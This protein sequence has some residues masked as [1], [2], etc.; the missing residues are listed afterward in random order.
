MFFSKRSNFITRLANDKKQALIVRLTHLAEVGY[1]RLIL[2]HVQINKCVCLYRLFAVLKVVQ[3][4][5]NT[6]YWVT[7]YSLWI[8]T[9]QIYISYT[10]FIE[11]FFYSF[12]NENLASYHFVAGLACK[13]VLRWLG[14][15][16]CLNWRALIT[17]ESY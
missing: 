12:K 4:P 10:S 1:F 17:E 6:M 13:G 2:S 8:S 5:V 15:E 9:L 11:I 3:F 14:F 16:I 7:N